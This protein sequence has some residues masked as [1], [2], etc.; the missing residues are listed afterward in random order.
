MGLAVIFFGTG[1]GGFC[2]GFLKNAG[3]EGGFSMV[4]TWFFAR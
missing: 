1:E 4:R 3:A 2:R